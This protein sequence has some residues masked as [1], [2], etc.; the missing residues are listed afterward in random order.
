MNSQVLENQA[1]NYQ[2]HLADA[3]SIPSFGLEKKEKQRRTDGL[4]LLS[5]HLGNVSV[6]LLSLKITWST[7]KF[8][9]FI[10]A[11]RNFCFCLGN[12]DVLIVI[13]RRDAVWRQAFGCW[14]FSQ[15]YHVVF[16]YWD[17]VVSSQAPSAGCEWICAIVF[18]KRRHIISLALC[19][20][21]FS[22]WKMKDF[23]FSKVQTAVLNGLVS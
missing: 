5:Q 3:V 1:T 23:F 10:N 2:G 6:R 21:L 18:A 11:E 4:W 15:L 14:L 9:I 16:A 13:A 8:R 22:F 12:T 7:Q 17:N 20:L 19:Q